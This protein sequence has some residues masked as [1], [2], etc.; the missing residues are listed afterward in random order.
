M[1]ENPVMK[2]IMERRSI[3]R[4]SR[5]SVPDDLLNEVLE[6]GRW[7]P[8]GLNNQPWRFA[9]VRSAEMRDVISRLTKYGKIIRTCSA[10]IAVFFHVESGYHRD[11]DMMG[12]GACMQNM[13]LAA[14]SLGLGAVWLGEILAKREEVNTAMGI[15]SGYEL[16]SVIA[17]GYPVESPR[18]R[19]VALEKLVLKRL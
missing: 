5:V 1:A 8:S 4:F 17:L 7:A 16:S 6:A 11:K 14:H 2:A 13:L 3:R 15:G 9:V 10:F 19:R 18:G 12:M